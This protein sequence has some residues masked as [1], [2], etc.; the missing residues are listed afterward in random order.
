MEKFP[1]TS[2]CCKHLKSL[3]DQLSNVG[4]PVSN[5]RHAMQLIYG[6]TDA[7]AM[8]ARKSFM[9]TRFPLFTRLA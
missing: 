7:Y 4:A 8:V 6:L 1:N 2:S 5:E 9:E 3:F